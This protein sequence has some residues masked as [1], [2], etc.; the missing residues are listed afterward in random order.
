MASGSSSSH[1]AAYSS[2]ST[3][4]V[5]ERPPHDERDDGSWIE[6][7][8]TESVHIAPEDDQVVSSRRA[9]LI[10]ALALLCACSLSIGSH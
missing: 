6:E 5:P 9:Y 8:E 3:H 7:D 1:L 2:I 10:R 4:D